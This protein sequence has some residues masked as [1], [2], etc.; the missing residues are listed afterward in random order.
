MYDE[1]NY[2]TSKIVYAALTLASCQ[3]ELLLFFFFRRSKHEQF[4]QCMGLWAKLWVSEIWFVFSSESSNFQWYLYTT[5]KTIFKCVIP[6]WESPKYHVSF[7]Y[8]NGFGKCWTWQIKGVNFST[9]RVRKSLCTRA[10]HARTGSQHW[11][12]YA[13]FD[14]NVICVQTYHNGRMRL[15]CPSEYGT[16]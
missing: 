12:S 16:R 13:N 8:S 5:Y 15:R 10:Q 11:S 7:R 6:G 14:H 4:W 3:D 1:E 2:P 9:T